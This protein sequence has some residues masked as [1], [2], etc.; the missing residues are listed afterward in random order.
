MYM[1]LYFAVTL[2]NVV[3]ETENHS[4]KTIK[5]WGERYHALSQVIDFEFYHNTFMAEEPMAVV[6]DTLSA[7]IPAGSL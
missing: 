7:Y 3:L 6:A 2:V 4:H 5:S 1:Y